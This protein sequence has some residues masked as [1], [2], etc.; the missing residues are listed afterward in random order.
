[1]AGRPFV[2]QHEIPKWPARVKELT[3]EGIDAAIQS[4][5]RAPLV[6]PKIQEYY[7]NVYDPHKYHDR[8]MERAVKQWNLKLAP[9]P[10]FEVPMHVP[11]ELIDV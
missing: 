5:I 11:E 10:E 6:S 7:R 1:M 2:S 9:K 8:V 3:V 4:T